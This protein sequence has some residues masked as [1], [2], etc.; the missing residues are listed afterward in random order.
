MKLNPVTREP[1][2]GTE[3]EMACNEVLRGTRTSKIILYTDYKVRDPIP[4]LFLLHTSRPT[5]FMD[6]G[7]NTP[8]P[9]Q[10]DMDSLNTRYLL[11]YEESIV[12]YSLRL[13]TY[14]SSYI[15]RFHPYPRFIA[16]SIDDDEMVRVL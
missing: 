12:P 11:T 3:N 9:A 10:V 4:H 8:S 6:F 1:P 5:R 13:P 7:D 2:R 15:R 14:R 16:S